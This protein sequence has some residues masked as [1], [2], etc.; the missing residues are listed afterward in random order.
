MQKRWA[1]LLL[2]FLAAAAIPG[3]GLAD[4]PREA[5]SGWVIVE[6]RPGPGEALAAGDASEATH[7]RAYRSLPVPPG[8]P[9]DEYAAL[10]RLDPRVVSAQADATVFATAL[11]DDPYYGPEQAS[12]LGQIGV[13]AA[14]NTA[15]GKSTITVAVLDTGL[16]L[17]HEDFAGRLWENQADANSN[18]IDDDGNGCIDD[19]YGC[20]FINLD[21]NRERD[22]GY[23]SS[24]RTGAVLDDHGKPGATSHSHGTMVSGIIG[25]AGN[26]GKGIAGVAWDVKIMAIKVLDCGTLAHGGLPSGEMFNVAEGIRY[27]QR[28]GAQIIN[29]SLASAPGDQKADNPALR[30][31]IQAAQNQGILIVT[32][33]GNHG[34]NPSQPGPGYPAAYTQF[35]N[36]V[37]V[38]STD[39]TVGNT[40]A[41]F[42]AYGPAIDFAAPG[43]NIAS[44]TRTALGSYGRDKGTSYSTPLVTGMFVLMMA[45]NSGLSYSELLQIAASAATPAPPAGH[46]QNWAGAGVINIGAALERMPMAVTGTPMHDWKDLPPGTEVRATVDGSECGSTTSFGFGP[47]TRF[48]LR[49]MATAESAGCGAPGK[50]VQLHFGG[51]PATPTLPWGGLNADLSVINR[52]ISTVSPDPGAIVVQPLGNSWSNIAHLDADGPLPNALS[53][54]PNNWVAAMRWN[55]GSPGEGGGS[56]FLVAAR[57]APAYVSNWPSIQRYEALW[58]D[59]S[60]AN[61]ATLNP[62]PVAGRTVQLMPG[63]NNIVYTGT[64]LPVDDALASIAG[65]FELV[66]RFDNST[67]AWL[68]HLPG[69]SRYLNDFGGLLK[70]QVYWVLVTEPATL[71]MN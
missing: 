4:S 38:G 31:A 45:R 32:A 28:M 29:L 13:P 68:T 25:A 59:A 17:A 22:C 37:A 61:V 18:G 53:Y 60:A 57:S 20:R 6:Y 5:G 16:D 64:S 10:L 36:V 27:A 7:S 50:T 11:P 35:P 42:S 39:N 47:V 71:T 41:S 43:F 21:K 12:Y 9:A 30:E 23:T 69:R 44:T 1:G 48:V 26:N 66:M 51:T 65:K 55:P 62:N 8:V 67:G 70:L 63:W 2:C 49:V 19:R 40:W 54:L 34:S 46:G 3:T 14:W 15:T 24:E 33:A 58:I 56:G 52:D